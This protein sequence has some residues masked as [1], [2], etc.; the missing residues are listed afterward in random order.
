MLDDLLYT[1]STQRML[2]ALRSENTVLL[3]SALDGVRLNT[4]LAVSVVDGAYTVV[5]G[6]VA[7]A[8]P[9]ALDK[10][11]LRLSDFHDLPQLYRLEE[12]AASP[13]VRLAVETIR[14]AFVRVAAPEIRR[15]ESQ[16]VCLDAST[17]SVSIRMPGQAAWLSASWCDDHAVEPL[18]EI[19]DAAVP[20]VALLWPTRSE[21]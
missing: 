17:I 7:H 20:L 21:T 16:M 2:D 13:A 9:E 5:R 1:H 11:L 3:L 18:R 12:F 15:S 10:R 19:A 6:E 8:L 4:A 14:V